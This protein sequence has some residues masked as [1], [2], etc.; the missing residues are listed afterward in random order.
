[1]KIDHLI[2]GPYETNCYIL[3]ANEQAEDC[4]IVDTGLEAQELVDFLIANN[5]KPTAVVLTHGHADH[6]TGV[7]ALR[8]NYP[9]MKV[10][11]HKLDAGMLTGK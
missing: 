8:E 10:Y 11:I 7:A 5:L 3:R 1:M 2:L 4:V 9:D 6:I